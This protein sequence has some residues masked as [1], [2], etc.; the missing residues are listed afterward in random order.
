MIYKKDNLKIMIAGAAGMVGSAI[1]RAYLRKLNS[2][3]QN[4]FTLLTPTRSDLDFSI[5]SK[6]DQWFKKNKPDIVIIA[7]AKVGGIYA[8]QSKPYEFILDNLKIQ[9]NLIE[10][11]YKYR[12]KKL[13]FLG[14][15]CIYPKFS[16]QPIEEECLLDGRLEITNQYYA[17]AKIAGIKLC[18]ALAVEKNSMQYR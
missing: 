18:E 11:S 7:A 13:L 2:Q 5:Y 9:T 14:S 12:V 4:N 16:S 6:V 15:S 3:M 17:I 1:K 10:I 8:N